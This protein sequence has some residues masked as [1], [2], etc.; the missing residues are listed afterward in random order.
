MRFKARIN[1]LR[2]IVIPV[3]PDYCPHGLEIRYLVDNELTA[4]NDR[5]IT[6]KTFTDEESAHQPGSMCPEC[7]RE[8]N[9]ILV[10]YKDRAKDLSEQLT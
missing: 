2:K 10:V 7:E 8:K 4:P 6:G 1:K 9:V 5:Y 3:G